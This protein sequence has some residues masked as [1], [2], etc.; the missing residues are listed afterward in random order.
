[1]STTQINSDISETELE[2]EMRLDMASREQIES[3]KNQTRKF[4]TTVH[5][6]MRMSCDH[7]NPEDIKARLVTLSEV[8]PSSSM[9]KA[10]CIK[11]FHKKKL[12]ITEAYLADPE[13][14]KLGPQMVKDLAKDKC[15]DEIA[16]LELCEDTTKGLAEQIGILRTLLSLYKEEL[17]AKIVFNQK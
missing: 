13:K 15:Y 5:R 2:R 10:T 9:A 8:L 4:L 11:I 7:T 14:K 17:A 16:L 3:L 6:V 1:M 12:E